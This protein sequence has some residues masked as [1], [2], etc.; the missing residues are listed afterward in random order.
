[1]AVSLTHTTAATGVDSGDGKISKNAWNEA[2]TL[3]AADGKLLGASGSTTV[4]EITVGT[5]LSLAAGTLSNT[6]TASSPAGSGTEIQYRA[7][8]SFGAMAGTAWDNTNRSLAV[9]GA[10]VTTSNPILDLTQTWNAAGV[11]FTALKCSITSTASAA[12]SVVQDWL[13][14]GSRI[15]AIR[16]DG[17]ILGD[18]ANPYLELS[19]GNG[20]TLAYSTSN[21]FLGSDIVITAPN[22]YRL[23]L[24]GFTATLASDANYVLAQRASTNAQE[25]RVY[26]TYTDASNYSRLSITPTAI[27]TQGAGTGPNFPLLVISSAAGGSITIGSNFAF[28]PGN[29]TVGTTTFQGVLSTKGRT[30]G[31]VTK[32][33][34]YTAAVNDHVILGNATT[35]A[36][37]VT[38]PT[39][40][41]VA[42]AGQVFV[43]KKIDAS[44]NAVTVGTTSSQ[45]IDGAATKVL[46]AQYDKV[47]VMSDNA[48]WVIIG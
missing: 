42:G 35:A 14:G 38:L 19:S 8:G 12:A 47:M 25:F 6:V 29:T 20:T 5:G 16:K 46:S 4:G 3:T 17:R 24:G 10:T 41:N 40:V 7:S 34:A 36:F 9:T 30:Y 39:A 28:S 2:H 15:L 21:I 48:N 37:Q 27:A 45:T 44:A 31:N 13:V 32:T 33:G 18:G 43:I 23:N 11:T 1:M 26:S 22:Q